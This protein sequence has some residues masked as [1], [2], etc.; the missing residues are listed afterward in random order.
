M[1]YAGIFYND[2]KTPIKRVLINLEKQK[3]KIDKLKEFL[4]RLKHNN[5]NRNYIE[6][7]QINNDKNIIENTKENENNINNENNEITSI[8]NINKKEKTDIENNNIISIS[9][10]DKVV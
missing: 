5:E 8:N 2:K 10:N 6:N 1:E 9:V 3:N 7:N 4:A